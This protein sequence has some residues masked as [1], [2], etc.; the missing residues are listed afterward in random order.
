MSLHRG[1]SL[2]VGAPLAQYREY[3]HA[4]RPWRPSQRIV[5]LAFF[6]TSDPSRANLG[7]PPGP[8]NARIVLHCVG[9]YCTMKCWKLLCYQWHKQSNVVRPDPSKTSLE[10]AHNLKVVGS[11]PTPATIVTIPRVP[12][13]FTV[14][15]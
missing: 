6:R 8:E 4:L 14:S 9:R 7:S 3:L 11:N 15:S 13:S 12:S 1:A 2:E 10:L 5:R